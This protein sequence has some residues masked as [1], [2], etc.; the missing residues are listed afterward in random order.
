MA[1]TP[2]SRPTD[3][4]EARIYDLLRKLP[5]CCYFYHEP[6]PAGHRPDFVV[7]IPKQGVLII[8]AKGWKADSVQRVSHE[9]VWLRSDNCEISVKHPE[10]QARNYAQGI[11]KRLYSCEDSSELVE[12]KGK[13]K[14]K[15][16]FPVS[17]VVTFCNISKPQLDR[18]GIT[19]CFPT[20]VTITRDQI[21]AWKALE[22][23]Q[24]EA[25]LAGYMHFR[26][27]NPL[28]GKQ[29]DI[30][31]S[32]IYPIRVPD[33]QEIKVLDQR[34]EELACHIGPGH[35]II[36]G[37]PGS[38]KTVILIARAKYLAEE[39][40]KKV[41]VLCYNRFLKEYIT[42][43]L[44]S[45]A[46]ISVN[47]FDGW[48]YQYG[49]NI[50]RYP[51]DE[52]RGSV[53]LQRLLENG[54]AQEKFDSVLID[55]AQI[56]PCDWLRCATI[57]LRDQNPESASLFV[58][59][60]G[61]QSLR[62]MLPYSW[63]DAWIQARGRTT[64][65]RINYRNTYEILSTASSVWQG[66]PLVDGPRDPVPAEPESC[67]R[68][69]PEPLLVSLNRRTDEVEFA[70]L[71]IR[72]WLLGGCRI[73]GVVV[74]PRPE[75]IAIIYPRR[76]PNMSM[77]GVADHLEEL[78][79]STPVARLFGK[80]GSKLSDPGVRL[81][82]IRKATGLQFRFTIL[83]WTDLLPSDFPDDDDAASLYMAMTR[84][85]DV[86]V[87]LHSGHSGLIDKIKTAIVPC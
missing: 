37:V 60:D 79:H 16:C 78:L 33:S 8:E 67:I 12:I 13:Y 46:N 73:N 50:E 55:E 19:E 14:G 28:S 25:Q 15:L 87:V 57:A 40:D 9:N 75:D 77:D 32:I 71:K 31:R 34:Q 20:D 69:G 82:T 39:R 52:A 62:K 86:L 74:K 6:R 18:L 11:S 30:I 81:L 7:I 38:G 64:V 80:N 54:R 72:E 68:N 17:W 36:R 10:S 42:N 53:F 21:L 3:P 24:L 70:A 59:V 44:K 1:Q 41:L 56:M 84:A 45:H 22:P 61:A 58:V 49:I 43:N 65:L 83:M 23:E 29:I 47:T 4:C 26:P 27:V 76:L 5:D 63:K 35:R 85:E 2:S 66:K 48:C 51:S